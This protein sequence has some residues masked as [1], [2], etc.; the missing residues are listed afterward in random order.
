MPDVRGDDGHERQD[1]FGLAQARENPE[2]Q[3]ER[4][5]NAEAVEDRVVGG[6]LDVTI[7]QQL[8]IRKHLRRVKSKRGYHRQQQADDEPQRRATEKREQRHAARSVNFLL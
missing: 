8:T 2:H 4:G 3:A 7:G 1:E 5:G 6:G